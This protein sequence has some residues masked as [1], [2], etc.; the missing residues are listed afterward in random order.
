MPADESGQGNTVSETVS[1]TPDD[2]FYGEADYKTVIFSSF[3]EIA[4]IALISNQEDYSEYFEKDGQTFSKDEMADLI[5]ALSKMPI[6]VL[7][8]DEYELAIISCDIYL[9]G[10]YYIELVYNGEH[11]RLRTGTGT[12]DGALSEDTKVTDTVADTITLG[13]YTVQMYTM[14]EENN[15]CDLKGR[16]VIDGYVVYAHYKGGTVL[17]DSLK[18]GLTLTTLDE[19][20]KPYIK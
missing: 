2:E 12:L 4:E 16:V 20:I 11:D 15:Y 7:N 13:E 17:P 6:P 9:D 10:R 19:L 18:Q 1:D 8:A 5:G 14:V 3:E